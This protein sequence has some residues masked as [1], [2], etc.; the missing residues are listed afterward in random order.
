MVI[1]RGSLFPDVMLG[2]ADGM[3][4]HGS[5]AIKFAESCV[6]GSTRF[7]PLT[8]AGYWPDPYPFNGQT[9][10]YRR[11][12]RPKGPLPVAIETVTESGA[13]T[14]WRQRLSA[15]GGAQSLRISRSGAGIGTETVANVPVLHGV[16]HQQQ[17]RGNM[18]RVHGL[19][20]HGTEHWAC[21]R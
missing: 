13:V 14:S 7:R 18:Q 17:R 4:E 1:R 5:P 10:R 20:D 2:G 6:A 9:G 8:Y 21:P 19:E 16:A 12:R 3:A 15:A 11:T